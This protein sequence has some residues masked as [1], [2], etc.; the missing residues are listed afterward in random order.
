MTFWLF[1]LLK[2]WS[3]YKYLVFFMWVSLCKV[4]CV[5]KI[6]RL[7]AIHDTKTTFF[8]IFKKKKH[9]NSTLNSNHGWSAEQVRMYVWHTRLTK[10]RTKKSCLIHKR[11][12]EI[13]KIFDNN[14]IR[15]SSVFTG[16][17]I[18]RELIVLRLILFLFKSKFQWKM[19]FTLLIL[20]T[21]VLVFYKYVKFRHSYWK[22][23]GIK[24]PEPT[25]LV[26]NFFNAFLQKEAYI[27]EID[28][29]YKYCISYLAMEKL[30]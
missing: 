15:S 19:Y 20:A 22:K 4:F 28:H 27:Y 29:V 25:F 3:I 9:S 12:H 5:S 11:T 13:H 26:G 8:Q 14:Y 6:Q 7:I 17:W 18:G 23:K 2:Y 21:L 30:N 16:I 1:V 24:G 10:N